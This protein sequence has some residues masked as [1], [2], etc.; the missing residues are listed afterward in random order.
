M[1]L[2]NGANG[3]F[4]SHISNLGKGHIDLAKL[5]CYAVGPTDSQRLALGLDLVSVANPRQVLETLGSL[6]GS[7]LF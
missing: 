2:G 4:G 1:T 7:I 6:L 3:R 5:L